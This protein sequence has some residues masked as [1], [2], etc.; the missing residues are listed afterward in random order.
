MPVIVIVADGARY[1]ALAGD[2]GAFP[3]LERL[4][5]EGGLHPVTTV[6][7]SVTGP[8]YAPFLMGRFPGA[9]GV[10]GL[11]WYDRSRARCGW[12][13]HAR[14]YVGYEIGRIDSD[15]DPTAPTIFELAPHSLAALSVITRGLAPSRRVGSL[16]VR[17]AARAA[18]T[19]F[20]GRAERWLD[21]DREVVETMTRRMREERPDYLFAALTGIDKASHARGHDDP[22]VHNALGIVD[23]MAER[24]RADAE[25]GGWWEDTQ[26]WIV[27]DHGHTAVHGHDELRDVIGALGLRAVSHPWSA[28][29]AP[30]AAVM[31]SG[32]AMA[33]VYLALD[34]RERPWWPAL[35]PAHEAMLARLLE[36]ASVDLVLLSH[37]ADRCEIRSG[38]H[39]SAWVT[40]TG[41]RYAYER[42]TG[43]PLRLGADIGGSAD[44]THD[45]LRDSDYPDALVQIIAL[46]GSSRAGDM[47]LSAAPGWDFRARYEPIPHRSAHGALHREHM[48]V[49]LLCNRRPVR[50]PRRTTD[51][52]ASTLAALGIRATGEMDGES[53]L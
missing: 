50:A 30:Q 15:L 24:L 22:L 9:V 7:P 33:H 26:L 27:S 32:N 1:D 52:F 51:V 38:A 42:T 31:V 41:G 37:A 28:G 29:F 5:A 13:D 14:S 16:T 45:A 47:I 8:A 44:E 2:L 4:R 6:F 35:A 19:H 53:F 48:L 36:R 11:R 23:E 17:M 3:A 12:P 39:G 43:D 34:E 49:P 18:L 25:R 21:V 40:R 46:A 20:R 10:P